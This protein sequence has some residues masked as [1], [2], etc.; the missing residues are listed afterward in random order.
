M[1]EF[2]F[3]G[4]NRE[5]LRYLGA[6]KNSG[7]DMLPLIEKVKEEAKNILRFRW[8]YDVY[9][10]NQEYSGVILKNTEVLLKGHDIKNHLKNSSKCIILAATLGNEIDRK[11]NYYQKFDMVKALIMNACATAFIEEGCDFVEGLVKE[12]YCSHNEDL[13]WRYSPGY[14]DLPLDIQ[15]ELLKALQRKKDIG[16]YVSQSNMLIPK[17]SVTAIIGIIP[18]GK[19]ISKRS[20]DNCLGKNN[21]IYRKNGESCEN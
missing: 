15:E 3:K 7:E 8:I 13:T 11:I 9:S 18:R 14:G 6:G 20:C 12:E 5:I 17:K 21:C 2:I 10:I 19:K 4:D 16:L 1:K